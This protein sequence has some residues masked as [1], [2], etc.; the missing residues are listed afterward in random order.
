V[1]VAELGPFDPEDTD[2]VKVSRGLAVPCRLCERV[3]RQVRLTGRYC[4]CCEQGFCESE[5]GGSTISGR[6]SWIECSRHA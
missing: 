1:P 4:A 5:H 3:S 6:G 2:R